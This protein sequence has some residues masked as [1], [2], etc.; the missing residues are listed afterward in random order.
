V[1]TPERDLAFMERAL[2]WAERG[3]GRTSP[4]PLVGAVVVSSDGV[5]VGQGAHM[6]AGG[7]HA[8]VAAL[9]AAGAR[10]RGATLYCTLEPCAHRGRTGPCVEPI[11]AAGVRRVVAAVIDPNPQVS[12]RGFAWLR[13]RGIEVTTGV[14]EDRASALNAPFFTWVARRRPFVIAKVATS[15]DRFVGQTA[16]RVKLTGPEADRHFHRQRSEIDAIAVGAGT[17]GVDDPELTARGAFRE[18]PLVRVLFDWRGRIASTARVFS[19]LSA[20]P[21]IMMV[22]RQALVAAP[23]R[24]AALE[25][26]G[27]TIE[28]RETRDLKGALERLAARDILSLLV[29]GGPAL[30]AAFAEAEL[31]DRAQ[32]VVTPRELGTGVP[33][34]P[35]FTRLVTPPHEPSRVTQLGE[36]VLIEFDV[37]GTDRSHRPH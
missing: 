9:E 12:G 10:A 27:V 3:R 37:H 7:V 20:G 30:H 26:R 32:W 16:S 22:T 23:E 34:A 28:A 6:R 18:R 15:R 25:A 19:T 1:V 5:V 33:L 29:E 14:G 2:F 13:E 24:F 36:D 11:A 35:L 17:V 21:V 31:I 8:E 4:N